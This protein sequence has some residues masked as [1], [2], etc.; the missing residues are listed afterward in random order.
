MKRGI[1]KLRSAVVTV[2]GARRRVG[3]VADDPLC[4][5]AALAECET[6]IADPETNPRRRLEMRWL[7]ATL[8]IVAP[9]KHAG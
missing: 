7:K 4:C 2:C 1:K 8:E 6:V 3:E 9:P 5:A